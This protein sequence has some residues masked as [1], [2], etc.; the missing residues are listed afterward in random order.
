MLE[1]YKNL[2]VGDVQDCR[3]I[4]PDGWATIHACK[5][6]CHINDVGY[7]GSLPQSHPNYLIAEKEKDIF[8]NMVDMEREL[9]P[10]Y[11]NPIMKAAMAF[12]EKHI[13][14]KKVLVHCNQG[15]SRSPSISLLYLSRIGQV[16]DESF[17]NAVIDFKPK[18]PNYNPARG[19]ALY[20]SRNWEV[21]KSKEFLNEK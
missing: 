5:H 10:V 15:M 9:S 12:I 21:L 13:S 2:F 18:Y 6:P 7:R 4:S 14:G 20:M 17:E 11:T 1:V 19:I 16:S 3:F 8:L